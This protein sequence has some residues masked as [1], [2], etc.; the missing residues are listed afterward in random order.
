M[1]GIQ[2][3]TSRLEEK[4]LRDIERILGELFRSAGAKV[5]RHTVTKADNTGEKEALTVSFPGQQINPTIYPSDYEEQIRNGATA[6]DVAK[7]MAERIRAHMPEKQGLTGAPELTRETLS[8]KAYACVCNTERN[9]D[10]L[11]N[12]PHEE[13]EDLSEFVK[14]RVADNAAI[15]ITNDVAKNLHLTGEEILAM[16]RRNTDKQEFSVRPLQSVLAGAFGEDFYQQVPMVPQ[17]YVMSNDNNVDGASCIAS[18]TA[19]DKAREKVGEDFYIIPSSRHE[20]LLVPV[21]MGL[22]I[23][24]LREMI[25]SVNETEVSAQDYLSDNLYH[26]NGMKFSIAEEASA[27]RQEAPAMVQRHAM[28]M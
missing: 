24:D 25:H 17:V 10:F 4:M 18:R 22:N 20:I 3:E 23:N 7:A 8:T 26:Y 16:A 1:S 14:F 12:V 15:T 5:S 27:E 13:I 2:E 9:K 21:S 6:E 19:L 28:A 11:K